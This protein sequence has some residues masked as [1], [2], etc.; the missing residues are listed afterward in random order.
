[1]RRICSSAG[2]SRLRILLA[3]GSKGRGRTAR[4]FF[5]QRIIVASVRNFSARAGIHFA[6]SALLLCDSFLFVLSTPS[7]RSNRCV[8]ISILPRL[9]NIR[10][11]IATKEINAGGVLTNNRTLVAVPVFARG[12]TVLALNI[13]IP[14]RRT[15]SRAI[16]IVLPLRRRIRSNLSGLMSGGGRRRS[17]LLG[18]NITG[19]RGLGVNHRIT[20]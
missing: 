8:V 14:L 16:G 19:R 18:R 15:V 20:P 7:G 6:L 11:R 9:P 5:L 12:S 2:P 10:P 1:M 13:N 17:G 4:V 3:L